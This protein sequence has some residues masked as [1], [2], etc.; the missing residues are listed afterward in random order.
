MRHQF[1]AYSPSDIRHCHQHGY[2]TRY[3]I[4]QAPDIPP[5]MFMCNSRFRALVSIVR[6]Y[7]AMDRQDDLASL[8]AVVRS[9]LET[10]P[11]PNQLLAGAD[12]EGFARAEMEKVKAFKG[13]LKMLENG[14]VVASI[15]KI[16]EAVD[17][18][19]Y[20]V[21]FN[22]FTEAPMLGQ[23]PFNDSILSTIR[24]RLETEYGIKVAGE[25]FGEIMREHA[26]RQP[27]NPIIQDL[28]QEEWDG[29]SRL[30]RWLVDIAGA[31][32]T[33][34]TKH[35]GRLIIFGM[36]ARAYFPGFK[37]DYMPVF[38]GKQ[39][40]GKSTL[41]MILAGGLE[42]FT[43]R[44]QFD[45][46]DKAVLQATQG[47]WVVEVAELAG[48]RK[49][50][51]EIIKS[52]ITRQVDIGRMAYDRYVTQRP[53]KFIFIGTTNDKIILSDD[54][55]NRRFLPIEVGD[56]DTDKMRREGNQIFAEALVEIRDE[57][58]GSV[59]V[60]DGAEFWDGGEHVNIAQESE[61]VLGRLIETP[62]D[63]I[64]ELNEARENARFVGNEE[65]ELE[66]L[67]GR[68]NEAGAAYGWLTVKQ[69]CQKLMVEASSNSKEYR[70]VRRALVALGFEQRTFRYGGRRT[71]VLYRPNPESVDVQTR[72]VLDPQQSLL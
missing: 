9:Y 30:N 52:E 57:T 11:V 34:M 37:F 54:T 19:R 29:L 20:D 1:Y 32:D 63:L 16:C 53:R 36:I 71:R 56:I 49:A 35:V 58:A 66:T 21:W 43:D 33:P 72:N 45:G 48:L 55:G 22:D 7:A 47:K 14:R 6:Y 38:I 28:E 18:L 59:T 25:R 2:S 5:I 17:F 64:A 10:F 40:C 44:I 23:L 67:L 27:Y 13:N 69:A 51:M 68:S 31:A 24:L 70:A 65:A 42:Y 39:G 60:E 41:A 26:R 62:A 61:T 3:Q 12:A 15:P 50:D 46:D 4:R 8:V